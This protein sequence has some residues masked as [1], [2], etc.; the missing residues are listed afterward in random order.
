MEPDPKVEVEVLAVK[1][2]TA[3]RMLDCST[4]KVYDLIRRGVLK[5]IPFDADQRIPVQQV[6]DLAARGVQRELA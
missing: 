5:T 1:P 6:R 3:G 2:V 4:T